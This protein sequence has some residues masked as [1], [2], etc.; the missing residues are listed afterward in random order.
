M[1][2]MPQWL[3]FSVL[4]TVM[5]NSNIEIIMRASFL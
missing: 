3:R 1:N 4:L 5:G 2:N